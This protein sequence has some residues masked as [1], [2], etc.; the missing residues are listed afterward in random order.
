MRDMK[1][2]S[3]FGKTLL[4]ENEV[5]KLLISDDKV[6]LQQKYSYLLIDFTKIVKMFLRLEI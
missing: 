3:C 5:D 4:T 1:Q 6:V 2:T